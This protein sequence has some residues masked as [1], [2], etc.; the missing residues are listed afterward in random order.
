MRNPALSARQRALFAAGGFGA[1]ALNQSRAVW[2]VFFYAPPADADH[3]GYL[4]LT[5]VTV[6]LFAGRLLESFDDVVIGWWS[7]RFRS[8][9]GRRIPFI[10][11]A[12][13]LWALTAVLLFM[14]PTDSSTARI[15]LQFLVTLM[16]FHFFATLSQG[17]YES[18]L[19]ELASTSVERVGISAQR[20]YFGIGGAAVGLVGSGLLV[21]TVGFQAMAVTMG[22]LT[23]ATRYLGLAGVW[24]EARQ[25]RPG[26][27][28]GLTESLRAIFSN[29]AFIAFLP[30][31]V[32]FQIGLLLLTSVVPFY[33][34]AILGK[35]DE[36]IWS[37]ILT[38]VAIVAMAAALSYFRRY[39]RAT[40]KRAAY[41][42]AMLAA[43]CAFPLLALPGLVAEI[44]L[45]PHV[46]LSLALVGAPVAGVFLFPGPL[47][48]DICDEDRRV[49]GLRREATFYGGQAFVEKTA[50]SLAPLVLGLL[51]LLGNTAG[52]SLGVRLVGPV[53][54]LFVLLGYLSFRR[55][56]LPDEIDIVQDPGE[57]V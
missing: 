1:E 3:S 28:V 10:L 7:D 21:D 47:T 23:L 15:A 8:P 31:F 44:P 43:A 32:C 56:D 40:S 51:L 34:R 14:P 36:G 24:R 46:I 26:D 41:S 19:P 55:Y 27:S 20:V 5:L 17:P 25:S 12:T 33:V 42:R 29:R 37:S 39:A 50:S 54:A 48:A 49:S 2:L 11:G 4:S 52:D 30:S 53:A 57:C 35:D 22:L 9:W 45:T 13:P 6:L 38:G 16:F 18:L